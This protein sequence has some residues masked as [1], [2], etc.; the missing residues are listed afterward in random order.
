M[1]IKKP[2]DN[3]GQGAL[4]SCE[5]GTN[6]T[7]TISVKTIRKCGKKKYIIEFKKPCAKRKLSQ[8]TFNDILSTIDEEITL[9]KSTTVSDDWNNESSAKDS[10]DEA[11]DE[12]VS[13]D[14]DTL[15]EGNSTNA[16]TAEQMQGNDSLMDVNGKE[17]GIKPICV[18]TINNFGG[19]G[20][21]Y[22]IQLR[23]P[24][25]G[26]RRSKALV[27][28][29]DGTVTKHN[30]SEK[31]YVIDFR[32]KS[33]TNKS[34]S[35]DRETT[36]EKI[37][38]T[39]T[40][41]YCLCKR[42]I[43]SKSNLLE[44]KVRCKCH[45][46]T[47]RDSEFRGRNFVLKFETPTPKGTNQLTGS[48]N[49]S[50]YQQTLTDETISGSSGEED[51]PEENCTCRGGEPKP[52]CVRTIK[53][54]GA[55]GRKYVIQFRGPCPKSKKMLET[56]EDG[57][58]AYSIN[59]GTSIE[60]DSTE[61]TNTSSEQ[62]IPINQREL[63][64]SPSTNDICGKRKCVRKKLTPRG[65]YI[66]EKETCSTYKEY[67]YGIKSEGEL[68]PCSEEKPMIW[69]RNTTP[70]ISGDWKTNLRKYVKGMSEQVSDFF[71]DKVFNGV[72]ID[73]G[74]FFAKKFG[75][76]NKQNIILELVK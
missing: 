16:E 37:I 51:F 12:N 53:K 31:K 75:E 35:V 41:R 4:E 70:G 60:T 74:T 34:Y 45:E 19:K 13:S 32:R 64:V 58:I 11:I 8:Q 20:K 71:E 54:L 55:T 3:I 72:M 43:E 33:N 67:R 40:G 42:S 47:L 62:I 46:D 21:K 61:K 18:K 48:R 24:C 39:D 2:S 28:V 25:Q 65:P 22:V 9:K 6:K 73:V 29:D 49:F 68:C 30:I 27:Q 69:H 63:G 76:Y 15:N 5:C 17:N 66:C 10:E 14:N 26:R 7:K 44:N 38:R 57:T 1:E 59:R 56:A 36:T 23:R 52:V 50:V